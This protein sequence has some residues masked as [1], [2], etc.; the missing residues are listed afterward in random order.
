MAPAA[1]L[2]APDIEVYQRCTKIP[3][4]TR[5]VAN[6]LLKSFGSGER[7]VQRG[8]GYLNVYRCP[9]CNGWHIGHLNA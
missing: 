7:D 4:D 6:R 8:R 9:I 2:R 1:Y 3:Y 5:H